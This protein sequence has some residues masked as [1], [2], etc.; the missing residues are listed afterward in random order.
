MKIGIIGYG[1][2]GKSLANGF[3]SNVEIYKVDPKLST[4]IK[5]LKIFDPDVIFICVPTPM[6]DDSS[7]DISAVMETINHINRYDIKS[8]IVLK[9]TVLPNYVEDIKLKIP[10]LVLNPEFLREKFAEEER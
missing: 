4:N 7:Q 6:K 8:L 5:G 1:F 3:N 10:D 9:S 2:V